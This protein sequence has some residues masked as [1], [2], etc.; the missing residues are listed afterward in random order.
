M[1][2]LGLTVQEVLPWFVE[3]QNSP[4]VLFRVPV[5]HARHWANLLSAAIRRCYISDEDLSRRAEEL[6]TDM[7]G[8]GASR[9]I[10]VIGAKLPD[11]GSTMAGDFGEIIT[12]LLQTARYDPLMVFGPKKWRLKQDRTKPAPYSDVVHFVLPDWPSAGEDDLLLCAEVKTKS[13]QGEFSPIGSAISD[14]AKDRT[15]RLA[16]TLVWLRDRAIAGSLG[17]TSVAHLN[18]FIQAT[19]FPPATRRF[20]AIAVV[21][22]GLLAQ[23][24]PDAPESESPD[25]ELVVVAIPDLKA[26]YQACFGAAASA[27]AIEGGDQ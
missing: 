22:S 25:Y 16:K 3:E 6:K 7:G 20:S 8:T 2:E 9:Q 15:S 27:T 23:E 12:Y 14:C 18:R 21:C 17:T 10:E 26:T 1:N 5:E 19:D 13:T 4:Y 24:V 11:P